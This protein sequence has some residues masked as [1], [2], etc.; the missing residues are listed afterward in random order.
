MFCFV[1]IRPPP[2]TTRTYTRFPDTTLFRSP[3]WR[4][5]GRG[6]YVPSDVDP[7][8]RDQRVVE[9]AAMLPDDWGGV[10]GWAGLSWLQGRWFD[11]SPWGR[12]EEHT[13]ELQ[14]LM[15]IL[16]AVFCLKK[17]NMTN[18]AQQHLNTTQ[19]H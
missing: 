8:D 11:G 1:S 17:N 15:R 14:S 19:Y 6:F 2:R 10:T 7:D 12:S 13:S 18:L 16:Y 9:A 4:R 3:G 5:T